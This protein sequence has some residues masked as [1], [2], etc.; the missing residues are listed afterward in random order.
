[1]TADP[2]V[3]VTSDWRTYTHSNPDICIAGCKQQTG[4][5]QNDYTNGFA[6]FVH[7]PSFLNP[8]VSG[9]PGGRRWG[10]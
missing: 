1:M 6:E 8:L 4:S 10:R 3:A 9:V 7:I 2:H 5:A